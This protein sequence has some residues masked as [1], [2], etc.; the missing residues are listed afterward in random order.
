MPRRK[1]WKISKARQDLEGTKTLSGEMGVMNLS[2]GGLSQHKKT[3]VSFEMGVMNL[4]DGSPS[5]RTKPS[6]DS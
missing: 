3:F 5:Q 4:S 1:Y 6:V 2:D